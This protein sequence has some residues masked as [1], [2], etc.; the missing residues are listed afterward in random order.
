MDFLILYSRL[1]I[2]L[3]V[4]IYPLIFL[5]LLASTSNLLGSFCCIS[6]D[7]SRLSVFF[8]SVISFQGTRSLFY[9]P[10]LLFLWLPF[11]NNCF[12]FHFLPLLIWGLV[13]PLGSSLRC[14]PGLRCPFGIQIFMVISTFTHNWFCYISC[15]FEHVSCFHFYLIIVHLFSI[16]LGSEGE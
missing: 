1:V 10:F 11:L 12:D 7:V 6:C 8:L 3:C 15:K 2:F 5:S 9:W 13:C 4:G 16:N 14:N